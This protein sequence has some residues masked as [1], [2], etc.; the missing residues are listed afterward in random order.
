MYM[1]WCCVGRIP[2]RLIQGMSVLHRIVFICLENESYFPY[3]KVVRQYFPSFEVER[4]QETFYDS[5]V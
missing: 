3:L 5:L 4:K 2:T 1:C